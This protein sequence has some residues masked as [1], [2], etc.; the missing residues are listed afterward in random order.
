MIPTDSNTLYT[1]VIFVPSVVGTKTESIHNITNHEVL[2]HVMT[3]FME[4]IRKVCIRISPDTLSR[5]NKY[6]PCATDTADD[7]LRKLEFVERVYTE[8]CSVMGIKDRLVWYVRSQ[9][10]VK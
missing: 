1:P 4:H 2:S 9:G 5:W 10:D 3:L 8:W 6:Y 7:I